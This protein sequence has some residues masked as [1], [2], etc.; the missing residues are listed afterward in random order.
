MIVLG[1]IEIHPKGF[2]IEDYC[3]NVKGFINFTLSNLKNISGGR[4]RC[5]YVKCKTKK[6]HQLDVLMMHLLRKGFVEKYLC[7]FAYEEPYIPYKTMLER[8]VG[9]TSTFRNINEVVDDNCS[10]YR[11][12]MID[13]IKI[14]YGYS[15]ES[16]RV[17]EESNIDAVR[18]FELFKD[19]DESLWDGCTN[20]S[21]LSAITRVFTVKSEYGLSKTHYDNIIEWVKNILPKW[22]KVKKHFYATK[23]MMKPLGLGLKRK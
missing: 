1:C 10:R 23:S 22:K 9:S 13:T 5:L 19:F 15:G 14:N 17:D 4:I 18:C 2:F 20:Y 8:I 12:M 21:N 6:F 3:K 16:S 7:W 11:S